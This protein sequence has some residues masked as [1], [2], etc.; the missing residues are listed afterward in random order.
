MTKKRTL[1]GKTRRFPIPAN[2][3]HQDRKNDYRRQA[4]HPKKENEEC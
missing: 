4:K 3:P 2:Q 1:P